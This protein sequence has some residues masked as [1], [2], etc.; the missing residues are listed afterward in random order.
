MR[1]LAASICTI[2]IVCLSSASGLAIPLN[3]DSVSKTNESLETIQ[4]RCD[5]F[6]RCYRFDPY[7]EYGYGSRFQ[8]PT[9]WERKGFVLLVKQKRV[10]AKTHKGLLTAAA[11]QDF[12][13]RN[14]SLTI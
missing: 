6:G 10:T 13:L 8:P 3:N 12:G 7:Q 5:E 4:M 1:M 11:A 9:K 14:P 2:G